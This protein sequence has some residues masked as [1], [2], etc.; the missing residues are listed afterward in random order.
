MS[1][2]GVLLAEFDCSF[3]LMLMGKFFV[4]FCRTGGGSGVDEVR[5]SLVWFSSGLRGGR[6]PSVFVNINC[7][8]VHNGNEPMSS[9]LFFISITMLAI[10]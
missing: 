7:F 6:N 9:T 4:S 2:R 10:L 3:D 1:A 5:A 8:N